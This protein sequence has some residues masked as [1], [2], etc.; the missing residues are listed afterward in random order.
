MDASVKLARQLGDWGAQPPENPPELV[1]GAEEA[2]F[3]VVFTAGF[4][5]PGTTMSFF[6]QSCRWVRVIV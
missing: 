4:R 5:P 2:G 3:D 1:G 6:R